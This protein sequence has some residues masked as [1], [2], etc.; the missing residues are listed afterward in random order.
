MFSEDLETENTSTCKAE[1]NEFL[2]LLHMLNVPV[3][4]FMC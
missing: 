3:M 4:L 1:V 2:Y